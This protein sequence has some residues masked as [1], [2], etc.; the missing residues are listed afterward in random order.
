MD[1]AFEAT[2]NILSLLL[3][4]VAEIEDRRRGISR[5]FFP[6]TF[7]GSIE[8]VSISH[9]NTCFV[10]RVKGFFGEKTFGSKRRNRLVSLVT[11][12]QLVFLSLFVDLLIVECLNFRIDGRKGRARIMVEKQ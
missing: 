1:C 7:R 10:A 9:Y 3:A 4:N 8:A 5:E 11:L 2:R 12:P 6:H